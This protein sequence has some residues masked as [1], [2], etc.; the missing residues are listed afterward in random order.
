[1][2]SASSPYNKAENNL[3]D[4]QDYQQDMAET[5][6][7]SLPANAPPT[8]FNVTPTGPGLVFPQPVGP[9]SME[10]TL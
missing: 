3:R 1:M 7:Y 10:M 6:N 9:K 8:V 2:D 4:I 5:P